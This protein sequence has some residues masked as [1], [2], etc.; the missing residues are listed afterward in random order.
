MGL[1]DWLQDQ[2]SNL[3]L[4]LMRLV[5]YRFTILRLI[6]VP[7]LFQAGAMFGTTQRQDL[8]QVPAHQK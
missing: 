8:R 6:V 2:E 1:R 7:M 3:G 5:F 4:E